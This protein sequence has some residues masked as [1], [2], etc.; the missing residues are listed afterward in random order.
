MCPRSV[1]SLPSFEV[2]FCENTM[3][4]NLTGEEFS[5]AIDEAYNQI[6]HWLPSLFMVP[7]GKYGK[8]FVMELTK[9]LNAFA[10]TSSQELFAVKAAMTL[11]A[12]LLQK[13]HSK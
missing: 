11:P 10:N 12:L 7:S 9:L 8:Q 4:Q 2:M 3:R 1:P 5:K 6:V 13:P